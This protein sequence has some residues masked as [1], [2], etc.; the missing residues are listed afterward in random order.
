MPGRAAVESAPQERLTPLFQSCQRY[1][2]L[3]RPVQVRLREL[4]VA[5]SAV[6]QLKA[7]RWM[8]SKIVSA[9]LEVQHWPDQRAMAGVQNQVMV[10]PA[11][12]AEVAVD[13]PAERRVL[14][15]LLWAAVAVTAEPELRYFD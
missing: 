11:V 6:E 7:V 12:P 8:S 1:P 9:Q 15:I 5:A 14:E 4:E 2:N 10:G 13:P 3:Y